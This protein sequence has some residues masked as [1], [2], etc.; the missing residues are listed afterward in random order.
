MSEI[1]EQEALRVTDLH[2]SF[3]DQPV[4]H[5]I[6]F[7]LL[8]GECLGI[9]GESGSG[10]STLARCLLTL[11]NWQSG[12]ITI[13][14]MNLKGLDSRGL[15]W[16]RSRIGAVFQHPAAA[17]NSRLRIIDSLME[18]LD[19]R[20]G[21]T[22]SFLNL[23]DAAGR[24]EI[25]CALLDTVGLPGDYVYKFPHELSGGEKQRITIAR[26]I[27]TEPDFIILDEP[28]AS[29]DV[30]TQSVI[31]NLLK[32]LQAKLGLS[33]LFISHDLAAVYYMCDRIMVMRGGH[34]VDQFKKADTFDHKRH[35]YTKLLI[36]VFNG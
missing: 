4:L 13:G 19:Q 35:A 31:L 21:C 14:D 24:L 29:L 33:Y 17:L 16:V 32:D 11:M 6:S 18:P 28:T 5:H 26:A 7:Q 22:P 23:D 20:K 3:A 27:S 1:Y 34:I 2:K 9:V 8:K 15:R 30:T 12:E 10:K 25:A 36:E